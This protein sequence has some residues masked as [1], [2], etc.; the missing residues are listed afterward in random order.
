[1]VKLVVNLGLVV[2]GVLMVAAPAAA[3]VD[4][5][6]A[7]ITHIQI[8]G[9]KVV[10]KQQGAPWRSVGDLSTVGVRER[11][12]A[13]LGAQHAARMVKVGYPDG[14]DCTKENFVTAAVMV[15]TY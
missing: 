5:S 14:Y 13:L 9:S 7:L 8:E 3:R 4:C 15:R 6:E 12:S 2:A 11:Y 1:M 10:Y